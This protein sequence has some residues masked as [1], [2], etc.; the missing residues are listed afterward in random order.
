MLA[1]KQRGP[2]WAIATGEQQ[3]GELNTQLTTAR[4]A[5]AEAKLNSI[6]SLM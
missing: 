4:A 6:A 5:K 3:L 1:L 2:Q